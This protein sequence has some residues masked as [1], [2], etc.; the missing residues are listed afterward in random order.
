MSFPIDIT[1]PNAPNDPADDQPK[2][3]DNFANIN[4]FLSVDHISPGAV[5]NGKHLQVQLISQAPPAF[6]SGFGNLYS[7]TIGGVSQLFFSPDN[8]TNNYQLTRAIAASFALFGANSAYGTP[9]ATFTQNGGW[10][11]LPGNLLFQYGF[12]GKAGATGTSGTVQFPVTFTTGP[13]SINLS[14]YRNSGNQTF[15]INS[16]IPPTTSSFSFLTSSAGSDGF[17]WTAVGV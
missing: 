16:L 8:S 11:F 15:T 2:I 12:Y 7:N 5:N 13:F 9:P 14:L 1:I 4:S 6:I 10:T 3:K 17:Y